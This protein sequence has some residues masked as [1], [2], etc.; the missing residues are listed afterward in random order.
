MVSDIIQQAAARGPKMCARA[1]APPAELA[2]KV[3]VL[4]VTGCLTE[5]C[6]QE[7]FCS[8]YKKWKHKRPM[9]QHA[10]TAHSTAAC[11]EK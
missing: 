3:Y 2:L 5:I 9:A 11:C 8:T 4:S 10:S 7:A 6:C 1:R